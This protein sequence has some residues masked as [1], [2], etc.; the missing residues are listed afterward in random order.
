MDKLVVTKATRKDA[1]LLKKLEFDC[2]GKSEENFEF[3]LAN[4]NYLYLIA[5]LN[6]VE[7]GYIGVSISFEQSDLL[8]ICIKKDFRGKGCATVLFNSMLTLLKEKGVR[9]ILLEVNEHNMPA[10]NL[11]N[12]LGFEQINIRKNYYGDKSAIIMQKTL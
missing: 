5:R 7:I 9:T 4:E 6:N 1:H 2:F 11:Y 10:I 3:V 8:Y 12:K